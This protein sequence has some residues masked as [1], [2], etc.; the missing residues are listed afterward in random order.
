MFLRVIIARR[1]LAR[2]QSGSAS[3]AWTRHEFWPGRRG[4]VYDELCLG[5]AGTGG[6]TSLDA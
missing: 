4:H 6:P 5:S 3:R 2:P 1:V